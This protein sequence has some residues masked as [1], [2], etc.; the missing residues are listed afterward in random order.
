MV[1]VELECR[2]RLEE[3]GDWFAKVT[4]GRKW[5]MAAQWLFIPLTALFHLPEIVLP[6]LQ[7]GRAHADTP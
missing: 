1:A 4:V 5:G 7:H 6:W 2:M 3:E